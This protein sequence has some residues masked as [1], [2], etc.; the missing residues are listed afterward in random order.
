M[1]DGEVFVCPSGKRIPC[2][3]GCQLK[4]LLSWWGI[5][6]DGTCGCDAFAAQMDSWGP[7]GCAAREDE[8]LGHLAEAAVRR[9]LPFVPPAARVLIR[10]AIANASKEVAHATPQ[11]EA[12]ADAGRPG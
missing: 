2:G 9:G 6:D 11:A 10:Q 8:I 3:P 12:G 7:D 4:R 5:R 1:G